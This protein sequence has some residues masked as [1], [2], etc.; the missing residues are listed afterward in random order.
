M[1]PSQDLLDRTVELKQELLEFSRSRRYRREFEAEIREAVPQDRPADEDE[2]IGILDRL[3][4]QHTF[5]DGLT[6]VES[7]VRRHPR[8]PEAERRML[9]GWRDVRQ[10]V[11]RIDGIHDGGL[12]LF[13]LVDDLS[14]LAY[15]NV[16]EAFVES[17][18]V[19]TYLFARLVPLGDVWLFSGGVLPIPADMEDLAYETAMRM[20]QTM[21]RVVF[22]NPAKLE[23]GRALQ[24]EER[25]DF[26]AYFGSDLVVLAGR[27]VARKMDAYLRW[28][29]TEKLDEDGKTAF[30]RAREANQKPPKLSDLAFS[31]QFHDVESVGVIYDEIDGLNFFPEF[32]M[33]EET[34]ADPTLVA[35]ADHA[36]LALYYLEEPTMIPL[37][38]RRLVE[39]YPANADLVFQ[40]LLDDPTFTWQRSGEA[41]LRE[42]KPDYFARPP[43]PSVTPI[44]DTLLRPD[45]NK[46][47]TRHV[48]R[49]D[50]CP[51]GSGR[52]YKH[53]HGRNNR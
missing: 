27:D 32:K 12:S 1:P 36:D 9:L 17:V 8:L 13:N 34:F 29:M 28:R 30:E 10:G 11:F 23:E 16:G 18:G 24:R 25:L 50:P 35:D 20:A 44:G 15:S 2:L 47:S 38:L 4:L 14:Y 31:N 52:K 39:R 43:L 3:L 53:C 6:I 49:N 37:P 51:C 26:I 5:S 19:G 42:L 22:Q 46:A 40:A 33:V 45:R 7:Y 21:P 41:L 48:G